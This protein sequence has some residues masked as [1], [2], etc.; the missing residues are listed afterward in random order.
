MMVDDG[1]CGATMVVGVRVQW[2]DRVW[3]RDRGFE[4]VLGGGPVVVHG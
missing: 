2:F 1:G 3:I 4:M